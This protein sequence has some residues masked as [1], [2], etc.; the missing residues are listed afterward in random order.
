MIL[1]FKTKRDINGNTYWLWL[2]VDAHVY[3]YYDRLGLEPIEVT[4][5]QMRELKET[6]KA[7]GYKEVE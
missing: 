4:R 5:K 7:D 1:E 3:G 6:A 2:D